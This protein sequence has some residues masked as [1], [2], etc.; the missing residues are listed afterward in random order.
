MIELVFVLGIMVPLSI[1]SWG[2]ALF[3][4]ACGL[5]HLRDM[6]QEKGII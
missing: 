4:T 6:L 3:L 2:T 5:I 1:V